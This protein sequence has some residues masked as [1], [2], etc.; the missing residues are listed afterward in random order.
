[1]LSADH[2]SAVIAGEVTRHHRGAWV[3]SRPSGHVLT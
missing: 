1:M 3:C 2:D